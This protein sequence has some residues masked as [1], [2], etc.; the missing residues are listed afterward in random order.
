MVGTLVLA[1]FV[2]NQKS[3]NILVIYEIPMDDES[4]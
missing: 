1:I 3:K 4:P 2:Q